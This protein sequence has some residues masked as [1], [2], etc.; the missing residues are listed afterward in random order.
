[1]GSTLITTS[2]RQVIL[3]GGAQAANIF[4]QVGSSATLGTTSVFKG[5]ILALASITANTGATLDGRALARNGAVA[6]D[7][8]T[9]TVPKPVTA[10][11]ILVSAA[12]VTGPYTDTAAQS[13]NLATKTITVPLS[14]NMQFYRIRSNTA[15]TMTSIKISGGNVVITYN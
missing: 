3:S 4:W 8:N 12:V 2:G 10:S 7:A 5:N 13:V 15:L 1:M 14:G 11:V 9:I 6:L